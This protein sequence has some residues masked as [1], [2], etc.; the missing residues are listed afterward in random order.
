MY[1]NFIQ[2][3]MDEYDFNDAIEEIPNEEIFNVE[4]EGRP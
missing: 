3:N 1:C 4:N 2:D